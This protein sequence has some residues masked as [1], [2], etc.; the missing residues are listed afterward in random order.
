M[1]V[2]L[3]LLMFCNHCM[4]V[5]YLMIK[6]LFYARSMRLNSM[7]RTK[8]S[9]HRK[10][11]RWRYSQAFLLHHVKISSHLLWEL[12]P[13]ST[14]WY[15]LHTH[16]F[17]IVWKQILWSHLSDSIPWKFLVNFRRRTR[18]D[19]RCST[20][21]NCQG[22]CL[23]SELSHFA[24]YVLKS[25]WFTV[26]TQLPWAH[27]LCDASLSLLFSSLKHRDKH[28]SQGIVVFLVQRFVRC[29]RLHRQPNQLFDTSFP[30]SYAF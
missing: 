1:V 2:L 6:M 5:W 23:D 18:T 4:N 3:L 24:L 11:K 19:K 14:W 20:W 7:H 13:V 9:I 28:E 25:F 21:N 15:A 17:M 22:I 29:S 10:W 27:L 8:H 26:D 12:E 30:F 16:I